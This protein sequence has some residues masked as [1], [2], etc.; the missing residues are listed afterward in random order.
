MLKHD[1]IVSRDYAPA[2][3]IKELVKFIDN[4]VNTK[5]AILALRTLN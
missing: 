5:R 4:S 2:H 1:D 3:M